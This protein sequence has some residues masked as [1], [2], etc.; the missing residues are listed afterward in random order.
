MDN[1]LSKYNSKSNHELEVRFKNITADIFKTLYKCANDNWKSEL[2]YSLNII[3]PASKSVFDK[4]IQRKIFKPPQAQSVQTDCYKKK[5]IDGYADKT[6]FIHYNVILSE[7]QPTAVISGNP[8]TLRYKIRTSFAISKDWRLDMT[9]SY[10]SS[11]LTTSTVKS[12]LMKIFIPTT[13]DKFL[14]DFTD[15]FDMFSSYEIECEYIGQEKPTESDINDNLHKIF[16]CI[17]PNYIDILKFN[18]E[19]HY[20][21]TFLG[22]VYGRP[23]IKKLLPNAKSLSRNTYSEIFPPT[24]YFLT[25]KADGERTLITL[26]DGRLNILTSTA[27]VYDVENHP[28]TIVEGELLNKKEVY[29]FDALWYKGER[30]IDQTFTERYILLKE[31]AEFL[32]S[33]QEQAKIKKADSIKFVAKTFTALSDPDFEKKKTQFEKVW[34]TKYPY[35][36]DGLMI[37]SPDEPYFTTRTYK[38]KPVET[39]TIDFLA[40]QV[41]DNLRNALI[42]TKPNLETYMLFVGISS[43]LRN[44]LRIHPLPFED[45]ILGDISN[46][47]SGGTYMPIH[48]QPSIRGNVHW[49]FGEKGLHKKIVE[50]LY[51]NGNW[52]YVRTR[53]DRQAE[54]G[55][56]GNDYEI[57]ESIFMNAINPL[58]LADLSKPVSSYFQNN[59]TNYAAPNAM[60]RFVISNVFAEYLTDAEWILDLA[61]GRGGDL[62]RYA[63][64]GVKN[65]MFVDIDEDAIAE[66]VVR[67][68]HLQK[69]S[70]VSNLAVHVRQ[71]DLLQ[72]AT[73]NE[74]VISPPVPFHNVNGIVC[75]FALH[76][77]CQTAA[78][79]KNFKQLVDSFIKPGGVFIAAVMSGEK[80][81][82]LLKNIQFGEFW[83]S[84]DE[85][86]AIKRMYKSDKLTN[87]GQTIAIKLPFADLY[88]EPLCNV[89]YI[90][91]TFKEYKP[92]IINMSDYFNGFRGKNR[93]LYD[94]ITDIDKDFIS[95]HEIIVLK[96]KK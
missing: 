81:F 68:Y 35:E 18:N 89:E 77:M 67:K 63:H 82:N 12:M 58:T 20:L 36:I 31:I 7:E 38:W 10:Q 49:F 5:R 53:D 57:A 80:V 48:F 42:P 11:V 45:K 23:T 96:A 78:S 4:F 21:S 54:A 79:L 83:T 15:I 52:E 93:R 84:K 2:E 47:N 39:S 46:R 59:N 94:K 50:L 76:Y 29:L 17:Q 91:K 27:D 90:C 65:G 3:Y 64:I 33:V 6:E 32:N 14:N 61:A 25:D 95:L 1:V 37:I 85:L 73:Q 70:D 72:P 88:E 66:L 40:M 74:L 30:L 71:M 62:H 16:E 24:G 41:P 55:Y 60:K 43:R 22:K 34:Q 56:F 28:L 44:T 8:E 19:M 86:Y 26:H 69:K 92:H 75:N 9:L 13:A 51:N 87:T